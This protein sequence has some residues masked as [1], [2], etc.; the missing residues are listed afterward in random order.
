VVVVVVVFVEIIVS[1][2]RFSHTGSSFKNAGEV[3]GEIAGDISSKVSVA[4]TNK[5]TGEVASIGADECPIADVGAGDCPVAGI[6]AGNVAGAVE[7]T[8]GVASIVADTFTVTGIVTRVVIGTCAVVF[9][10]FG[11]FC[12]VAVLVVIVVVGSTVGGVCSEN[13]TLGRGV[14]I[15][16]RDGVGGLGDKERLE[17]SSLFN[18]SSKSSLNSY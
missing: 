12:G 5:G 9:K 4:G 11:V 14:F 1:G 18:H 2:D 7:V 3:A 10:T 15:L 8:N 17:R 6:V 13:S 16:V